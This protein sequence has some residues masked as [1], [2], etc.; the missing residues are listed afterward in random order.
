MM[1]FI[2]NILPLYPPPKG[3]IT[4]S[5]PFGG[6]YRGRI[7]YLT[8]LLITISLIAYYL[9]AYTF[10][11]TDFYALLTIYTILFLCFWGIYRFQKNN[12]NTLVGIALLFRIILLVAI[13]NLSQDFYRFIWDGSML[14]NGLNPYL[15]TPES[16]IE[17]KHF[18]IQQ[19]QE[20]YKG[21]GELNGSHFTNYPPINQLSFALANI[22]SFNTIQGAII[23]MRLQLILADIG[24][25]W[26]GKKLLTQL[27][28]PVHLIFLYLLNPFIII[29]LTGNLHYE[30]FMLFFL[31]LALYLLQT[32]RWKWAAVALAV[33]VA[34]KL[35]PLLLLPLFFQ[36]LKWKKLLI[37]YSIVL[38]IIVLTFLPFF[39]MEFVSNYT[40]TV[41][42]WFQNFEFNASFYYIARAI[43]YNISGY[44]QIALIGKIIP[45]V[46]ML[47]V[48][49]VTFFRK[50][51]TTK[52]L[53]TN[54]LLVLT[55]YYLLSTTVHPWYLASLVVLMPF[56]SLRFP[57][58]WSFVVFLSYY[59][60][61][62]PTFQESY[63]FLFIQYGVVLGWL[64]GEGKIIRE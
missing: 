18:P 64:T 55:C 63:T 44:N 45:I 26:I 60:Y 24:I 15:T 54:M 36:R 4:P 21:M 38:G 10:E 29:E 7:S 25:L 35:I 61:T 42:L 58:I 49:A 40:Q 32:N 41:G 20:L 53:I 22:F 19:A 56:T 51:I 16:F 46:V 17:A 48:L 14:L 9:F 47:I 13:P 34:V 57:L 33:S 2:R 11:R 30:G 37:F 12:F 39:S 23:A 62:T 27:N 6:G 5:S 31:M 43:G 28:L 52:Q 50:N 8:F 3:E 59:T 1:S